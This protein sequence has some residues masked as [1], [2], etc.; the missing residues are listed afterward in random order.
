[1]LNILKKIFTHKF[2]DKL[3]FDTSKR[4]WRNEIL[5]LSVS[6]ECERIRKNIS[7]RGKKERGAKEKGEKE[8]EWERK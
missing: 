2:H 7:C 8:M 5:I 6:F 1:M 4:G 3:Q